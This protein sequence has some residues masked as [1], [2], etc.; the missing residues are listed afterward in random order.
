VNP[1]NER[2]HEAQRSS[3]SSQSFPSRPLADL[4]G[5]PPGESYADLHVH[6]TGSDGL[7]EVRDWSSQARSTSLQLIAITDHDHF[8][9]VRR[10]HDAHRDVADNVLPG[11]EI[12]A[13]GQIVHIGV[14]F[15]RALPRELPAPGTPLFDVM[16]WARS[17]DG[18]IVVLVHPLP[19]LWRIQLRRLQRAGLLPDAI[20]THFPLAFW[21]TPAIERAAERY[22]LAKLGATDAH[23][24]PAQLGRYVTCFPGHSVDHLVKAIH[25]RTTRGVTRPVA[26]RLP[27]SVYALQSLFAWLLPYRDRPSI[28]SIRARLLTAARARTGAP[29]AGTLVPLPPQPAPGDG[30]GR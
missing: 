21:R 19:G 30:A 28:A 18:A 6:T 7:C 3:P 20:E 9:T 29:P 22:H 26:C 5:P 8:G 16:H 11:V 25:E 14:L 17:I 27:L 12:T 23:M 13:R 4:L 2:S 1:A 15:P 24:T 10:W